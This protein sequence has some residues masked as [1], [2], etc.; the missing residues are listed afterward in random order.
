MPLTHP[1]PH[2]IVKKAHQVGVEVIGD[3]EFFA[4]AVNARARKERPRVIAITGSNGKST[5][6]ALIGHVLKECGK[7]AVIGG[8]IGKPALSLPDIEPGRVYVLELSSFQLD[9]RED[10]PCQRRRAAQ[11]VARP[12]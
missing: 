5:T 7:D 2:A 11:S 10:A 12:S 6:T 9:L 8:N 4:R 3:I 1:A